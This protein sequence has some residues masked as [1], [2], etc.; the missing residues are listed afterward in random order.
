MKTH[1]FAFL[2]VF[3]CSSF[4]F[5]GDI[6]WKKITKEL[7]KTF[8]YIPSGTCH[9]DDQKISVNGFFA[10]K[11]EVS[12]L[13]YR[14]FLMSVKSQMKAED[15]AKLEVKKEGWLDFKGINNLAPIARNYHSH[16]AF[17]N[18]PVVNISKSGAEAYCKWLEEKLN[19]NQDLG[20][21]KITVRL[22]SRA[23]WVMAAKGGRSEAI[24]PWGGYALRN[25]KVQLLANFTIKGDEH[26]RK[27][28]ET[29]NLEV[30]VD[31]GHA[32][33]NFT[34]PVE[35]YY[36]NDFGLYNTSGNVAEMTRKD[37]EAV[38]GSWDDVG[39]DIRIESTSSYE[40]H[41]PTVG[42]RPIIQFTDG[43]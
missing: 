6:K 29:G 27:N 31:A 9:I 28:K 8:A 4:T 11:N 33:N 14:E 42:F 43:E 35:H 21:G 16:P 5:N 19:A 18:H 39:Y 17:D 20:E 23:E 1:Y 26:I 40:G 13:E 3:L 36:P 30:V 10:K 25:N 32:F 37:N 7:K 22:P 38:G 12:N 24:Y 34:K 41:A 2:L 15:F